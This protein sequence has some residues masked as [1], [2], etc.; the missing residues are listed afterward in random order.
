M[1]NESQRF[2]PRIGLLAGLVLASALAVAFAPHAGAQSS[3]FTAVNVTGAGTGAMQGTAVTIIDA[4]GDVAGIYRTSNGDAH[5]FVLPSG[6]VIAT[7]DAPNEADGTFPLGFDSAGD[8]VGIFEDTNNRIHGFLRNASTT[9]ITVLDVSGEDTGKMEGTFPAGINASGE[10]AGSYSTT[11]TTSSGTNSFAHGF[12]RSVGGVY[13]MFDAETLPTSYGST[14][15]GTYVIAINASGEVAGFYIDGAGAEHGFLRDASGTVSPFSAPGAGTAQE[16]GTVVTGID[17]AGDVIGVYTDSNNAIHGFVRNASTTAITTIDA[18]GAGSATYQGTYPDA[19]DSAGDIFGSFTDANNAVHGFVLPFGGT[20]TTYDA[21]GAIAPGV[22]SAASNTRL[23]TKLHQ[24]AKSYGFSHK[25]RNANSPA[26]KLKNLLGRVGVVTS[27]GTGLLN[28]SGPN[29]NGTASYGNLILNAGN[30]SGEVV[31]VFTDGDY[32]FHGYLRAA[33]G[34]I[35]TINDPG[36][37]TS[38][39]QGTGALG[40]NAS[41]LIAGTYADSNSM[42]HG[43]IYNSSVL[44]AT[45]TALTPVPTPNPSV[46]QE[47]V[48]LTAAVSS[49]S[50]TPANGEEVTFMSGA[51]SLGT[52]ELTSGVASLAVTTLPEGTDSITAVYGGDS[53][54]SGSTST[55]VSQLVNQASSSIT[56]KSSAN[57]STAGQSVTFTANISGQFGGVATGTV[58]FY[59]GAASLGSSPVTSN[60]A[61]L[62]ITTLP[63]GTDS[64]T[65]VYSGDSNFTG[66]TSGALSQVVNASAQ[67]ATPTFSLAAGTYTGAQAVTIGDTTSGAKIYFTTDGTTPT[68]GSSVYSAAVQVLSTETIQ[69]LAVAGGYTNSAVATAA[70]TI[71]GSFSAPGNFSPASISIQPGAATGNSATISVVGLNGFSGTVNLT[72]SITPVAANDPPTCTLAPAS[73]TLS[74]TTTQPSTLTVTTT[75]ATSALVRPVW[76]SLGG[77]ALAV[78][79]LLVVPRRRR[80]WLA[81]LVLLALAATIGIG[82]CGGGSGGGG[83]GGGGNPGTSAG[84]YSVKVTGTSGATSATVAAVTLTVQ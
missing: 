2:I 81:M 79:L 48:T 83:G 36:A 24:L 41:G 14:N 44:V 20:I 26:M 38:A 37:G 73:V 49:G 23:A 60:A 5:A 31:G 56:L 61:T 65:A 75:A 45:T 34:T 54:F 76:R 39:E 29:P 9:T 32:V 51:T 68:T 33:N 11:M 4:A 8:I 19:F 62:P 46:Y 70:Y 25:P 1:R 47:P 22:A 77:T 28:G 30:P 80:S 69:A 57:P 43:F 82:G 53:S 17:A 15:P 10:V 40:I 64:I 7:F 78:V 3:P 72:C 18:P 71:S 67:A 16:Q 12:V 27:E 55:A 42:L 50:G 21:P 59:N 66:I 52:S 58:T 74:G 84:T 63:V 13:S 6:G 35:T